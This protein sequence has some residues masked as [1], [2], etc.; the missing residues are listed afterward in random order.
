MQLTQQHLDHYNE[1]GWLVVEGVYSREETTSVADLALRLSREE[2]LERVHRGLTDAI[3]Y[4]SAG[5]PVPRKLGHPFQTGGVF[6]KFALNGRLQSMV[7]Q[8]LGKPPLLVVDQIFMKPPHYG[9]EKPWHQDNA[10]FQCSPANEVLTAWIA[11]DDADE[12]NGCLHYIDGSHRSPLLKHVP[13]QNEPHNKTPVAE[14][15]DMK[16]ISCAAVPRGGVVFHHS[17]TL[18]TSPPNKS[19]RWRRAYATHW[20]SADVTSEIETIDNAYYNTCPYLYSL[21]ANT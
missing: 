21:A 2:M 19:D 6:R 18:H 7:A 16:R 17:Q 8:L 4:D 14:Q 10:Y 1:R 5:M 3:D 12:F 9:S 11:L 15:I 13:L 20:A